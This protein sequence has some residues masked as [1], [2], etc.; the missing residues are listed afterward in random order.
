MGIISPQLL[1]FPYRTIPIVYYN[2]PGSM[3]DSTIAEAGSIYT[4][5]ERV[6]RSDGGM[7]TVDSSLSRG[8]YPFLIK[9]SQQDE[10]GRKE[11]WINKEA[12]SMR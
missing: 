12:T 3:H 4:K 10:H 7:C 11:L 6:Y 8:K 9:S 5:L 1:F 2:T